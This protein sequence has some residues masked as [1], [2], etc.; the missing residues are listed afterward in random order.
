MIF[1]LK[2]MVNLTLRWNLLI[3]HVIYWSN[4]EGLRAWIK[5]NR[6]VSKYNFEHLVQNVG[7]R[8]DLIVHALGIK[9]YMI[10]WINALT[11][12]SERK[13]ENARKKQKK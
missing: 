8:E 2:F 7:K 6:P 12:K 13:E 10:L 9:R 11:E 4:S 1:R 3:G 5:R